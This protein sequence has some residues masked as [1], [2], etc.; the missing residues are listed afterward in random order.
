VPEFELDLIRTNLFDGRPLGRGRAARLTVVS[1]P[2]AG[3]YEARLDGADR[4]YL[5]LVA[6]DR[7]GDA[8]RLAAGTPVYV[9][10]GDGGSRCEFGSV[11]AQLHE[12]LDQDD[13]SIA[14]LLP[15]EAQRMQRRRHMRVALSIPMRVARLPR[16][17]EPADAVLHLLTGRTT[18]IAGGGLSFLCADLAAVPGDLVALTIALPPQRHVTATAEVLRCD[19][20]GG[21]AI[22]F[23][24]IDEQAQA[25]LCRY[26]MEHR[27]DTASIAASSG[28]TP[29]GLDSRR[30][31]RL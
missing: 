21:Y 25:D 9:A 16:P 27:H 22:E 24:D 30:E 1:G 14:V 3:D 4:R 13:P 12:E 10:A 23:C 17:G 31:T 11:I 6:H 29:I 18:N 19:L 15:I 2:N 26:A 20:A 7:Y 5:Y 28:Q 8:V